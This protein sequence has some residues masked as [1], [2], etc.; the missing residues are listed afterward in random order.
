MFYIE[1]S[2]SPSSKNIQSL[3]S[4]ADNRVCRKC[5]NTFCVVF[6]QTL[7]IKRYIRRGKNVDKVYFLFIF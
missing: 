6:L 2:V 1:N 3:L 5:D 7:N 4:H